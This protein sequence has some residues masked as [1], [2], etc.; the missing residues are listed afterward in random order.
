M[1]RFVRDSPCPD[2]EDGAL[3]EPG[4]MAKRL[5]GEM[6]K[7]VEHIRHRL[8]RAFPDAAEEP[9]TP[10]ARPSRRRE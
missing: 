4:A 2:P 5:R 1:A 3:T 10:R 7:A 6:E 9:D 8:P